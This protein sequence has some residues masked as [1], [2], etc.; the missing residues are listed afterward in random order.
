MKI[1]IKGGLVIDPANNLN[2]IMDIFI[3][4]GRICRVA[5][6]IN[7]QA[8]EVINAA[9]KMVIPGIIDMH[10]HLREPGREDKE[11]VASGTK[12]GLK[13]GVTSILAMPNTQPVMDKPASIKLLKEIIQKTSQSHVFICGAITRER[14]GKELTKISTLKKLGVVAISDDGASVDAARLMLAALKEAKRNKMVVISHCE[15]KSLSGNGVMNLGAIST[16]LGLRGISRESEYKRVGRDIALAKKANASIH[17]A[18][19]SCQESVELIAEAK[20]RKVKVTAETCPHYFTFTE[21]ALLDY[22]TNFKINPPLR[23]KE[24]LEAIK[25]ALKDGTLDVIA[26]DHAPHTE[27]EKDVEFE[28]AEFG[29]IGLETL[30]AASATALVHSGLMDWPDLIKKFTLNPARILGLDKGTLSV[31]SDADIAIIEPCKEWVLKK[32]DIIS[33]SKNCAFVGTKFKGW[34]EYT[35]CAG[36]IAYY[37][38]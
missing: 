16:R 10:V 25:N 30:F 23:G 3:E 38:K 20:K 4:G 8:D 12:A 36:N 17:I 6:N 26:S 31:G 32:E 29:T 27:S 24:D 2:E 15:D 22:N 13:G 18:H 35:I 21:E 19:V 34:V 33:R 14:M 9:G 5:K 7:H 28:K 37:A 11:T 1:L